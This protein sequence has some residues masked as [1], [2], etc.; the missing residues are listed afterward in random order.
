MQSDLGAAIF[1]VEFFKF[2]A[3]GAVAG[4][5]RPCS[6][7]LIR[8][9]TDLH[10][11]RHHEGGIEPQAEVADDLVFIFDIFELL[12][13]LLGGGESDLVDI[14]AD[15]IGGHADA[16]VLDGQG[17]GI[18]VDADVDG[19]I[20]GNLQP[21]DDVDM[22]QLMNGVDRVG[23]QLPQENF[24]VAVEPFLDDGKDIFGM[25]G[26]AA[27]FNLFFLGHGSESSLGI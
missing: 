15:F 14:F 3:G 7:L 8:T 1:F 22:L 23:D 21:F 20:V 27:F 2:V 25:N 18:L 10:L 13:E 16:V 17:A 9:G 5:M 24:M 4:P 6:V 12:H 26:D 11:V 19:V